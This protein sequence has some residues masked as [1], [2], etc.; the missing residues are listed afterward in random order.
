MRNFDSKTVL[1][2]DD[3]LTMRMRLK[4]ILTKSGYDVIG[5]AENGVEAVERYRELRPSLVLM[6]ISMPDMD[7]ISAVRAIKVLHPDANIMMCTA[8]G[9]E[10]MVRESV[11]AG[12]KDFISK[13]IEEHELLEKVRNLIG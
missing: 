4:D 6:D 2:V 12:A 13:P 8:L 7:G 9:Q 11:Q 3:A 1:I 5:E 10:A